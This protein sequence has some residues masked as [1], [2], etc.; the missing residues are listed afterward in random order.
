MTILQDIRCKFGA[1]KWGPLQG[2]NW[3][4]FHECQYCKKTKRQG[5]SGHTPEA[6]DLDK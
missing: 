5:A 4:A 3:G 2:D 6:H 1:H